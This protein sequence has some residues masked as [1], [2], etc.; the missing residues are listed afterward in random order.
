MNKVYVVECKRTPI[1]GFMGGLSKLS[2]CQLGQ[3]VVRALDIDKTQID[4]SYVGNVLGAGTG[5]NI[6]RHIMLPCGVTTPAVTVN[7]V[8]GSGMQAIIEAYKTIKSGDAACAIAGGVESMSSAPFIDRHTRRGHKLGAVSVEDAVICDGLLDMFSNEQM[9]ILAEKTASVRG[10]S[11][12]QQDDQATHSYTRAR[13]AWLESKFAS[14]IVPVEIG[15]RKPCIVTE[16]EEVNKVPDLRELHSLRPAF[17]SSGTITAGNASTLSDGA[18]FLALASEEFAQ[19]NHLT[20]LAEIVAVDVTAGDPNRFTE[21]PA[22]SIRNAC[23]K[24]N[25]VP[26]IDIDLFEVNEA[27]STVPIIVAADLDVCPERMNIYGGA[28]ALGHPLGCSGARIVS[29]LITALHNESKSIGCASIC[30]GGG[31]ASSIVVKR[32]GLS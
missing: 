31:G 21:H 19:A 2:A 11:R 8:C 20:P 13:A 15:G 5:Q 23:A 27:F 1:G 12:A 7:T 26:T 9:G 17:N 18:C 10:I 29:T 4:I 3:T 32:N 30:N 6:A 28:V 14:E 22:V 24:A 25:L 16:D